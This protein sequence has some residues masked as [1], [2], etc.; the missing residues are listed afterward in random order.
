MWEIYDELIAAVPDDIVVKDCLAGLSWFLV[1]SAGTGVAMRPREMDAFI[2]AACSIKKM[3]V[4]ELAL[5]IAV[6]SRQ[7]HGEGDAR[8]SSRRHCAVFF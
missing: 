6:H 5:R 8:L 7:S 2:R 3:K 1:R 4:K